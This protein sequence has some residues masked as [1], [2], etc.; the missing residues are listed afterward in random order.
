MTLHQWQVDVT[1]ALLQLGVEHDR[2]IRLGS[3]LDYLDG[4]L[5]YTGGNAV[6][7][8]RIIISEAGL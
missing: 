2:A 5:H 8:A 1:T 3:D 4:L 7:A 6:A